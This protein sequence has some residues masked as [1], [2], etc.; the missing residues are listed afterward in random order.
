MPEQ[1]KSFFARD[2]TAFTLAALSNLS[3]FTPTYRSVLE[4]HCLQR[5]TLIALYG[6]RCRQCADRWQSVDARP[7][8]EAGRQLLESVGVP[9]IPLEHDAGVSAAFLLK[10]VKEI[11]AQMRTLRIWNLWGF[12]V[13]A[14]LIL[15]MRR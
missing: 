9:E 3:I 4:E 7:V 10:S 5:D 1:M 8:S 11:A 6:K 14:A 12:A 2:G 15:L 13:L